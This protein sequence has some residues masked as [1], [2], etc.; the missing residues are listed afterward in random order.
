MNHMTDDQVAQLPLAGARAA[1]LEEIMATPTLA[2]SRTPLAPRRVRRAAASLGAAAAVAAV[3]TAVFVV[4]DD[5]RQGSDAEVIY[6]ATQVD[7][8]EKIPRVA[9]D[10]AGWRVT[11]VVGFKNDNGMVTY[12]NADGTLSLELTWNPVSNYPSN[13]AER[14]TESQAPPEPIEVAG[15]DGVLVTYIPDRDYM[16]LLEPAGASFIEIRTQ[17][18]V[19][20]DAWQ[21][22]Q[23]VK[24]VLAHIQPVS[25]D[26]WL[27]RMPASVVTPVKA[28]E[29]VEVGLTGVPLPPGTAVSDFMDLGVNQ[30]DSFSS[31]LAG[32]VACSW[33]DAWGVAKASG[34]QAGMAA[35]VDALEGVESWPV[36]K[37]MGPEYFAG[38]VDWVLKDLRAG[39]LP[40]TESDHFGCE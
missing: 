15:H 14:T 4:T 21:S 40:S 2:P 18:P 3:I 25:V 11:E 37:D 26:Q 36:V 32:D 13:Y 9:L 5:R 27:A 24:D 16:V 22:V 10:M 29:A 12:S 39:R 38:S 8:A 31:R 1:L 23:R 30:R 17:T 35:A 28:A 6:P 20:P 33:I 34:D 7:A 19:D